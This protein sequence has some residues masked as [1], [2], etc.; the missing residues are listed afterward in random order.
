[1]FVNLENYDKEYFSKHKVYF[2]EQL[3]GKSVYVVF[4]KQ[5]IK[6][7]EIRKVMYTRNKREWLVDV[8]TMVRSIS[9]IGVSIFFDPKEAE[10]YQFEVMKEY[11]KRQQ[12]N[13]LIKKEEKRNK[14]IHDLY[15]LLEKYPTEESRRILPKNCST[16]A[17]NVDDPPAHTCDECESWFMQTGN[18]DT[19]W[20]PNQEYLDSIREF[21]GG[22]ENG[23]Q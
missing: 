8:D 22:E 6:E 16:C 11:N 7:V 13:L 12:E 14:E 2:L 20:E 21:V 9:E 18:E 19:M 5:G 3:I 15:R 10:T 1:M 17:F 4:P 23:I